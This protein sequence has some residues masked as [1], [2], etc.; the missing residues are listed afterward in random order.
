MKIQIFHIYFFNMD[1]LLIIALICLKMCM[2][3]SWMCME[4]SVSQILDIVLSFS[5]IVCRRWNLE[6]IKIQISLPRLA[7]G[8]QGVE[9]IDTINLTYVHTFIHFLYKS[10]LQKN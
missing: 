5:F 7:I 6:R 3:I 2:Y 9:R 10:S 8:V 1:I 4:G